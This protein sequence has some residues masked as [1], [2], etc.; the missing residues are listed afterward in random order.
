MVDPKASHL[1]DVP[2]AGLT[3][4]NRLLVQWQLGLRDQDVA[5]WLQLLKSPQQWDLSHESLLAK[6]SSL[7]L[8]AVVLYAN[9]HG[10]LAM[11]RKV[12]GSW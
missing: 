7:N 3:I 11:M 2:A 1:A 10:V 5:R 8:L 6:L 12:W 4:L 9:A